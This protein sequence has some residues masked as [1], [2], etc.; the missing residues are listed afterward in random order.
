[1]KYILILILILTPALSYGKIPDKADIYWLSQ[2]IYH[3]A[4][5]EC[6]IGKLLVGIVTLE[7]L[8][9]GRWGNTVKDV[10]TSKH[11]FSWYW[12]GKSDI[13]K[14][15]KEWKESKGVA[16]L[17]YMVYSV[18]NSTGIMY[19]H[20]KSVSPSWSKKMTKVITME[21]HIFYRE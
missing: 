5:G 21:N 16:I 12:D 18:F 15:K 14:N 1:M 17:T 4:R 13:P 10:V 8:D 6:N 3:E 11:Q 9:H 20:N 2:N 19:Y 7:R